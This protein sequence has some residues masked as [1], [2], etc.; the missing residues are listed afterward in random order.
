MFVPLL[1]CGQYKPDS[2][3]SAVNRLDDCSLE[4]DQQ[5]LRQVVLPK[6]RGP[7]LY[8]C[9]DFGLPLQVLGDCRPSRG[10]WGVGSY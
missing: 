4:V 9:V 8:D 6:L 10:K 5:L 1:F 7:F 2:D 3:G